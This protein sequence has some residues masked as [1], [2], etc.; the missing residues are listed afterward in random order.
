MRTSRLAHEVEHGTAA[1]AADVDRWARGRIVALSHEELWALLL[2][3]KN[4]IVGERLLARGGVH[5]CAVTARDVLRPIVRESASAFV[6][7]HNHPGG[8]PCPDR[9]DLSFTR[10]VQ[11][12]AAAVGVTLV[13]H[14]VVAREGHVSML[15]AGLFDELEG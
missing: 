3:A 14:V 15:E 7:V 6:L 4:R 13:D 1:S 2:D 9:E 10:H 12:G 5:A 8:D 11:A